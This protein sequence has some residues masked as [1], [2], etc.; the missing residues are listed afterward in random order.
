MS[1]QPP[2]FGFRRL[3][4]LA[5]I[6]LTQVAKQLVGIDSGV[7]A[8]APFELQ[9]IPSDRLNVLQHYQHRHIV[10]A[11]LPYAGPFV[12]TGRAGAMQ[13]K[14]PHRIDPV[15]PIAPLDAE[16]TLIEP[17]QILWFQLGVGHMQ[18]FHLADDHTD[19]VKKSTGGMRLPATTVT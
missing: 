11:Y 10:V 3:H 5:D 13:S 9:R 6:T 19:A 12:D 15:M 16:D 7:M 14:M 18:S 4:R 8:V 17:R 1:Q 2:A